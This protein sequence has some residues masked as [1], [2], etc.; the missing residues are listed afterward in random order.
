[1]ERIVAA[2][3]AKA[4]ERA[5]EIIAEA[6]R[7]ARE[8]RGDKNGLSE[9]K[10]KQRESGEELVTVRLPKTRELTD[11][12]FVA[13]NG[14][15]VIIPRGVD[16]QIK[17]KFYEVLKASEEQNMYAIDLINSITHE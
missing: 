14:E 4:E 13:V 11:D 8:I 2:A 6:E 16:V 5:A 7:K 12:K 15:N 9:M 3:V 17:R 10:K 1:M